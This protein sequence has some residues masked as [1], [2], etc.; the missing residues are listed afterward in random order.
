ML[1]DDPPWGPPCDGRNGKMAGDTESSSNASCGSGSPALVSAE[2][3]HVPDSSAT[4]LEPRL[5]LISVPL[6]SR[7]I[8]RRSSGPP[9]GAITKPSLETLLSQKAPAPEGL[10][11]P[12]RSGEVSC[13]LLR[14]SPGARSAEGR[15]CKNF[16]RPSGT[17]RRQGGKLAG[18]S[19]DEEG[20]SNCSLAVGCIFT[21]EVDC[22]MEGARGRCTRQ[23][24]PASSL[25]PPLV[26]G[27][28][29]KTT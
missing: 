12:V 29:V 16:T 28:R 5:E 15:C 23:G 4:R 1:A 8:D 9:F 18:R 7:S 24:A 20:P 6:R 13:E 3:P 14:G 25:R 27:H 2:V 17:G 19:G 26:Q 10:A 22:P 11:D 21:G